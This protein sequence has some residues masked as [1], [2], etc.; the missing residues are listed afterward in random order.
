M[1]NQPDRA[2][3]ET[4]T[5][6]TKS[7][8]A[9]G[10]VIRPKS[11]TDLAVESIRTTIVEG[12]LGMGEQ[13]SESALAE[14]LGISKTP[15]REALFQLK[16]QGLVDVHP[17]RGTFVFQLSEDD[18]R[19]ICSFRELIECAALA[20]AMEISRE[21]LCSGLELI[22]AHTLEAEKQGNYGA[23]PALDTRFHETIV[24][25]SQSQ[26]LCTSYDLISYKIQAL[27]SRL[28]AHDPKVDDCNHSHELLV[29]EIRTGNTAKAQKML[30]EH[31]RSTQESYIRASENRKRI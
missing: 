22:L 31:I 30:R 13:I 2:Q 17:Q 24:S 9:S 18:V 28:P 14:D 21:E 8:I 29:A 3:L 20:K 1:N 5:M 26:Y 15:V 11:L 23:I 12:R 6:S 10:K 7:V 25:H 4:A 16:L 19:E 27:R